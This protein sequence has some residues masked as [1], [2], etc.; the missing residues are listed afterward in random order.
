MVFL[1]VFAKMPGDVNPSFPLARKLVSLGHSV[2]YLCPDYRAAIEDTGARFLDA[3]EHYDLYKEGRTPE[4]FGAATQLHKELGFPASD[5]EYMV[6]VKIAN[7]E[8]EKK[9][10]GVIAAIEET[11]A[12]LI[13]YDPVLCREAAVAGQLL[14][15]PAVALLALNGHGSWAE[16][17]QSKM[18]NELPTIECEEE[19]TKEF[20]RQSMNEANLAATKR[21]NLAYGHKGMTLLDGCFTGG[22]LDPIPDVCLVTTTEEMRSL[23]TPDLVGES[24]VVYVGALLDVPGALR[25][26]G[27][28]VKDQWSTVETMMKERSETGNTIYVSMGTVTTA[29]GDLGWQGKPNSSL[30]GEQLCQAIWGAVFDAV[31]G[32]KGSG[33]VILATLGKDANGNP[34]PLATGEA[35]PG[36]ALCCA[37]MPQ[38]DILTH[39]IDLFVT[40]GGQNSFV[41]SIMLQTPMLV[42]PTVG[43]QISNAEQAV[44]MGIGG[45]VNRP[46]PS[47]VDAATVAAEYRLAVKD[48][49]LSLLSEKASYKSAVVQH[50][51]R[52]RGGGV[53]QAVAVLLDEIGSH[54]V[55]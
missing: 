26:G 52:Y 37:A 19:R 32:E 44:Q 6:R 28:T 4:T 36:N 42:V 25:A 5:G 7:I 21:L 34:R 23:P 45:K 30:T 20:R 27:P 15:I 14:R 29:D 35:V 10:G 12:D 24:Q 41:E 8:L 39:G 22:K 9:L 31:G 54:S 50:S 3:T 18:K 11:K 38:V 46:L 47:A 48:K 49:I 43:D 55:A 1:F 16:L 2:H 51:S 13:V 33:N 53:D 17:V 40:H